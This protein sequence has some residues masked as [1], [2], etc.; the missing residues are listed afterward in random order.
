MAYRIVWEECGVKNFQTL[1]KGCG[2]RQ[3]QAE[4]F[5]TYLALPKSANPRLIHFNPYR[6]F[7][8][9]DVTPTASNPI[10]LSALRHRSK[11]PEK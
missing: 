5:I 1:Q 6:K 3:A 2:L 4:Y 8:K 9:V 11:R 10:P 7:S